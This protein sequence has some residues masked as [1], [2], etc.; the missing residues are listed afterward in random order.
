MSKARC[1][2]DSLGG[3]NVPGDAPYG[4]QTTR[5]VHNFVISGLKPYRTFV[6]GMAVIKQEAAQVHVDLGMLDEERGKAIVEAA[7]EVVAPDKAAGWLAKNAI[8]K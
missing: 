4:A 7:R 5:A 1:E 6:W 8:L 2:K 3:I